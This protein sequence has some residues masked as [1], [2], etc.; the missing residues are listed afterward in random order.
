MKISTSNL[1]IVLFVASALVPLIWLLD[2]NVIYKW[3]QKRI[4]ARV[5]A[6]DPAE[7]LRGGRALLASRTGYVGTIKPSSTDVPLSI[8]RL[9]PTMIS[10]SKGSVSV[11]FSDVANPFGIIVYADGVNPPPQ[12]NSRIGPRMWIDGLWIYDDGQ[13]EAGSVG[14]DMVKQLKR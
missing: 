8:R 11:D 10:V 13:L 1:V 2:S 4:V 3:Q 6:A 7:L 14:G 5:L 9:K 12:R